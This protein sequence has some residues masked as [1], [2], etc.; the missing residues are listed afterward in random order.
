MPLVVYGIN[1]DEISSNTKLI[2]NPNCT[3]MGLV[4]ALKPLHDLFE[5]ESIV[6]VAYQAVSGSGTAA[7]NSLEKELSLGEHL[8]P[9]YADGYYTCLLYTSPSPRDKRQ[10]RMP[11]SA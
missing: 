5:L 6:P 11:S 9:Q 7:L 3:T 1:Q 10:S 4:M 2:S 8:T